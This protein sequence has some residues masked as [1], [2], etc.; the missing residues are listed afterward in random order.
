MITPIDQGAATP[1]QQQGQDQGQQQSQGESIA[2]QMLSDGSLPDMPAS[3]VPMRA[4]VAA[5]STV[6]PDAE[7]KTQQ[8]AQ[9]AG[10]GVD[11]TR[12]NPQAA[13][14]RAVAAD[15]DR[16]ELEIRNPILAQQL[17][18]PSFAAVAHDDLDSLSRIEQNAAG[19]RVGTISAPTPSERFYWNYE[20]PVARA[21]TRFWPTRV[22][23]D[24]VAGAAEMAGNIGSF[25]GLHGDGPTRENWLQRFAQAGSPEAVGIPSNQGD[26]AVK[27][28]AP[29]LATMPFSVGAGLAARTLGLSEN[30][31]KVLTALSVGSAFTADQGGRTF[32]Q[33]AAAGKS[34][35]EARHDA[36]LVAAYNAAPNIAMGLTDFVPG[37][38]DY[39]LLSAL[40]IGGATGAA[41][42]LAQNRVTGQPWQTDLGKGAIEGA[43]VQAGM[44]LGFDFLGQMADTVSAVEASKLRTRQPAAFQQLVDAVF[45]GDPSVRIPAQEFV[46]YF[47]GKNIDPAAM[48]NHLGAANLEEAAAAGSDLEI[49]KANF[50]GGL[51][52][53]H[54]KGLLPD[55]VDPATDMTAR[56]AE[57][58]HAE[59]KDW[60]ANGGAEK[61][62]AEFAQAD[63]ETQATPEWQ[64]V[65]S[66]LKQRYVDAGETEPMADRYATLQANAISYFANNSGM[67]PDELLKL[68][69]PKI[70]AGEA[71]P[72]VL[73]QSPVPGGSIDGETGEQATLHTPSGR[74]PAAYRLIEADKLIPS[75]NPQT[76]ARNPEYPEGVQERAYDTSKEAQARVI[77][78]AQNYE[79]AYTVNSNP[80][81]VNGPPVITPEGI[82]LGGNSRAMS[83][84]RLYAQGGDAYRDYLRQNAERFGFTPAQVDAMEKPVLVRQIAAPES[85]EGLRRLGSDLNKSMTG[86]LGVAER[87]VSAGKSIRPETFRW[88]ADTMNAEDLSLR[89]LMGRHGAEIVKRLG[90]DGVITDRERPQFVD[91]ST[92]GLSEEGKTFVER[93]L[94]GSVIDDPRLMD[95]APKSVLQKLERSLGA[96]TSFASREDE[97]NILPTL[98]A[99]IDELGSIQ[100]EGTTVELRLG[101]ASLFGGERNPVVD[102]MVRTLDGKPTAVKAAFDEFARDADQN[103]PGQAR[104]FGG[105]DAFDAF[106]RAFGSTLSEKEFHHGQDEAAETSIP[107]AEPEQAAH[108][109]GD[110]GV[111]ERAGGEPAPGGESSEGVLPQ[112]AEALHPAVATSGSTRGWYF[113][114]PDGSVEIGKTSLGDVSAFIHEPGHGYLDL[115]RTMTQRE[116][117][118]DRIKADFKKITDWLGTTPEE[119]YKNGYT[120]EQHEQ[121]ARATE[122][123]LREGKAPTSA[124]GRVF[125]QFGVFLQS[126]YRR[127]SALGVDMSDDVRGVMDRLYAGEN[128]VDRAERESNERWLFGKPEDAGWTEEQYRRYAEEKGMAVDDAKAQV[129]RELNEAAERERTKAWRDEFMD[130]RDAVTEQVDARPEYRAMRALRRG[131]LDDETP[132]TLNREALVNQFGEE[133]VAALNKLH[134]GLY[135]NEG[136]TDAETAAEIFG[137][138][139]GEEMMQALEAAPRRAQAIEAA[140]RESMTAKHGD[141]R[142]DG[143]LDDKARLAVENDER[144]KNLHREL[145]ALRAKIAGLEKKA[146]DSK[147][148]LASIT[149]APLEHYREAARQMVAQKA[150]ADLQPYRYL[151]ASRKWSREAFA[152]RNGSVRRAAEAKNKEL[153]NHFLFREAAAARDW[154]AKFEKRTQKAQTKG[155]QQRLGLADV[156]AKQ[157]GGVGDYRD[158]HNWI[159]A[160]L[161]L[162]PAS[163]APERS[164]RAWAEEMYGAGK[165]PAIAPGVLDSDRDRFQDWRGVPMSELRDV[166]DALVNIRHLAQQEFK[167]YV[168][169]KQVAFAEARA[170]MVNSARENLQVK[171]ERIFDEN[172]TAGERV[173][174]GLQ[175]ADA[176]L[177]RMERLV[178]WLDGGKAGPWHDNLWN[179]AS[180]AQGDEYALQHGVTKAVTDALADMPDEMRR[181][182]WTEKVNV[183]GVPEPLSRR[184]MLSM[185]FNMGN[186]GNLDRLRKTFD[187]FGWERGA[188]ERIGGMLTHEEWQFVQKAWDSLKPLG[189]RMTEMEK[190]LTGLP[191]AMVKVTPFKVVLDDGAEMDLAGGYFPIVM[192]P[193]FSERAITQEAKETAQ[194]AMQSGYVRATTSRGYTK[195]RTGFGGPLLLDYERALTSHVAKVAKDLSHREFMLSSQRLLLDTEVRKTLRET[196]GP[197]Y[198]RQFMPWLRTIINDRNGSVDQGLETVSNAMQR[199]RS[200][201]VAASVGFKAS[202]LMLQITH[203]P[204]M[205]LYARPGSLAQSLADFLA[206][207]IE[208]TR[209]IHA[210]SPNEMRFRGDNLDRD[211]RAVLANPSYKSAYTRKIAVA[212]RFSLATVD[213]L[214]SHVLWRAAF[215]DALGKYTE[216]PAE[217][218]QKK[219]VYE[220]D[221]AVRLGLNAQAPKDLPAIMRNNDFNK[222]ITTLYGFY[223]GVYNQLRDNFHQFRNDRNVV[224]LTYATALTALLP[225]V[226]GDLFTGHGPKNG[227]NPGLWAAKRATLFSAD[228]VPVLSSV[229]RYMEQGRDMQ[230]T[231]LESVMQQGAK[232]TM[233]ATSDKDE[234]D[235]LGIGLDAAGAAGQLLGVPGSQQMVKTARYVKAAN[236]GR[237]ENPNV[238]NAVMGGGR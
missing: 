183:E 227:E 95:A 66:D 130:T 77:Q 224:K 171:P 188:I 129:L 208:A 112:P 18:N 90:Q 221:S 69:N 164:L 186:E 113:M 205:L 107:G 22:A 182:L 207:P 29:V 187:S 115:Y 83:T 46:E 104:M 211:V 155:V 21:L 144:A 65:K 198:E 234:K 23:T 193:R 110:E 225:A 52:P 156:N 32:T 60:I 126:I 38:R 235:W 220:A 195:E 147:A 94:L 143:S 122:L 28:A 128:A 7:A 125:H 101:Q 10:M 100:R 63:A 216:L 181:R 54:Q 121:W 124:L 1:D 232:A 56:Q 189:E 34:D 217:E 127:A 44:H 229:G 35:A 173:G 85:T 86:A 47:H 196:L 37:L 75:H 174:G 149:I 68:H 194:N 140:T 154:A 162:G 78:Q 222:M 201:I 3:G 136:G 175:Y 177:T 146:T 210:L 111:S 176:L 88:A 91:S 214:F 179:L 148:A 160:R 30:A 236:E 16:R 202:T 131:K 228:T 132:L 11:L 8:L 161:R 212:A 31:G 153:L 158:Q 58:G 82:V 172:R 180:D 169:G 102:A 50:F 231:P 99:A 27:I 204:R 12:S 97:W 103:M 87:A 117:A 41:G 80:D 9:Q 33:M 213:H 74:I 48:A 120:T 89:E 184:R 226:L 106:N 15:L 20:Y 40:G 6:N 96:I 24:A 62:Q 142:Y 70:V 55:V 67:K 25:L 53:E 203:A 64:Q 19:M 237:V 49:P 191:P 133:R 157:A 61:L 59:L 118:S 137:F 168:Q 163:A 73:F 145:A 105:G 151:N 170:A 223:N 199:L 4:V 190:R 141:I 2:R 13:Q 159:L 109:A 209:E 43:G 93:A 152:L 218:A 219:A 238:W 79:P 98:R 150:P 165:E 200:N 119:V 5:S 76:F 215:N 84:Q 167:M 166:D 92:G 134:R 72:G 230:F 185:A 57:A 139:S 14:Q 233:E 17:S 123:Y 108:A 71:A 135:R 114:R 206:R 197:A 39:P 42:Q 116:G 138:H 36:N 192:D 178:E 81:A 45:D 26:A 51:S